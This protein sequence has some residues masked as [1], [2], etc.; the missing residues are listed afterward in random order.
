VATAWLST[1]SCP[2]TARSNTLSNTLIMSSTGRSAS[3]STNW[4]LFYRNDHD[5]EDDQQRS[6]IEPTSSTSSLR[7]RASLVGVS[8]SPT[9]FWAMLR[10]AP[11]GYYLPWQ[12]TED[13]LDANSATSPEALTMLQLLSGVDM[14]GAI[15]PPDTLA[16]LILYHCESLVSASNRRFNSTN[17][18][19]FAN[20]VNNKH[21]TLAKKVLALCQ[22]TTTTQS[23]PSSL[24][25]KASL[26]EVQVTTRPDAGPSLS[27]TCTIRGLGSLTFCPS[28][29]ALQ[30][31]L[32]QYSPKTSLA[33]T[34]LALA[35]RY[36][37]PITVSG[38]PPPPPS[39]SSIMSSPSSS[40]LLTLPA[41]QERFP[42]YATAMTLQQSSHRVQH[43]IVRGFEIHKLTGALKIA[44]RKGDVEA[45]TKIRQALDKYDSMDKLPTGSFQEDGVVQPTQLDHHHSEAAGG[46]FPQQN[47]TM[48]VF[49]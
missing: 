18:F 14:A 35:L 48:S 36:Q 31:V 4:V 37:A 8:L 19:F 32:Y 39:S 27:L 11:D 3:S 33:F 28:A 29:Q 42:M 13:P 45:A 41:L 44:T 47:M 17:M 46:L 2:S 24:V 20:H 38:I 9:G 12:V 34:C 15:L 23:P 7:C 43:N 1:S 22:K 49:E 25:P 26:D 6:S 40:L 30:A 21:V 16:K 10:V 5:D